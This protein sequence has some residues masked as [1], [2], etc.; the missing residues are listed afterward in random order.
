[1]A[2][3]KVLFTSHTANFQKFNRPFMRM[4]SEQGYEVHYASMGEEEIFDADKAFTVPFTRSPFKLSNVKAYKQL[5]EI[6]DREKYDLIHTHTPMGSVVTRL[7]AREARK[8]GM[9]VIYTAHGFHFFKGAP[10]LNWII[11]YPVEKWMAKHTDTLITI[12]DEDYERAKKKFKTDVRYVPGVGVNTKVFDI[13]DKDEKERLRAK[14]KIHD[15]S[16]VI[17]YAAELN[18]NK[19]QIFLIK[20]MPNIISEIPNAILMLCGEGRLTE[21]YRSEIKKLGLQDRV[22]LAGYRKDMPSIF[23][24]SDICVASSIREGM[25]LNLAEAMSCGL[26]VVA[27]RNR[28]HSSLVNSTDHGRLYKLDSSGDFIKCL[29]SIYR[30]NS[31]KGNAANVR[32]RE[33]IKESYSLE[34]VSL[35]MTSIYTGEKDV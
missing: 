6:I 15:N 7:A 14:N 30:G 13:A 34:R 10:L 4:L 5:K 35:S 26:P 2:K 17:V 19:N 21:R 8:R 16:V 29:V 11:Y 32:R 1:M 24:I 9:R 22:I 20:N 27:S 23:K 18:S 33:Y 12:N 3:K 25:G 28:G 31:K